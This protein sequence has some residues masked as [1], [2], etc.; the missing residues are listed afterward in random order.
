MKMKKTWKR[1]VAALF[2]VTM[3]ITGIPQT[4][5]AKEYWPKGPS[6]EAKSAIVMEVNTGTILY[7]KKS[8]TKRFP[9]S[10]TKI[11][12]TLLAIE[13]CD[14]DEK[15]TFS[16]DAVFKNEGNTSHI[17][18][19]LGEKLTVEQCIYAV[20]LE[21]ANECAYALAEHIGEKLGGDYRTFIDLM[22]KR[23]KELGC[24]NTHFNNCNG[25]PD[26]NHYVCAYDMALISGE[27]YKNETFR[28]ITGAPSYTIPATNKHDDPYYCHNH[29]KM[30]YPWQ[31]DYS[32][33]YDYC[34]GGKTG[35]TKVAGST[36]VSFAEKDGITLVC[37][38]LNANSPDHYTDTRKLMDYCFENFQA[39]NIS[40]NEKSIADDKER[41]R[42]LLNNND[43]FVRLDKDAYIIMP[44]AAKFEDAEFQEDKEN[45]GG[46]VAKLTYTYAGRV[47]GGASIETT[48]AKIEENYF[49]RKQDNT[50]KEENVIWIRP[51]YIVLGILG[52]AFLI[53]I[54][55]FVKRVY[56]NFYLI[57]HKHEMRRIEKARFKVND[58]K[59][60]YRKKDRLFK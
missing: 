14:M 9:A 18:R 60:R 10:I 41:N 37:V 22:N 50:K 11:M 7:E 48:G 57:R 53:F 28:I 40:E 4:T 54:I 45:L 31:G 13:N 51:V 52:C 49:D 32:H 16:E 35:F 1:V 55:F 6:V 59:K 38:V 25:L 27:A 29:H 24:V 15:V 12:T 43:V 33:L 19:N 56:D 3:V 26:E 47:V 17:S 42:G 5:Y 46:T 30:I 39:L 58:R 2:A 36:L 34:T 8:H 21:S 20:M 44:K 23:A